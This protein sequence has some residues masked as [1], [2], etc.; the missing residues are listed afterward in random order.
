MAPEPI[1]ETTTYTLAIVQASR[2]RRRGHRY[3]VGR[4]EAG[5]Q[6]GAMRTPPLRKAARA[7]VLDPDQ[8]VLL[9]HYDENDGF[10]ASPGGGLEPGEDYPTAVLRELREELGAE[11]V[12]LSA[13]IAERSTH[14][15]V[16]GLT[17]RQVEKYFLSRIAPGDIDPDRATQTD[18]IRSHRWWTLE[19]LR[20]TRETVYP[21][22]LS[23][24]VTWVLAEG[25]PEK[26]MILR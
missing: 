9:L 22:G 14:H 2:P 1:G 25:P 10:W 24:L 5:C 20:T 17:V 16:G 7:V 19:N 13:Q 12:D 18:N 4:D 23:E 8:R 15:P 11:K 21:H 6:T 3:L 26:P